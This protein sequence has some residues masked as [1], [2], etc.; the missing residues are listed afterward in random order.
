V[1]SITHGEIKAM[2]GGARFNL[3]KF[4]RSPGAAPGRIVLQPYVYTA[5]STAAH[6]G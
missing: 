5:P 3:S 6:A 4:N 1:Q 2:V